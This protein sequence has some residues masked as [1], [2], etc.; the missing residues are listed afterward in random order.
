[1]RD[2]AGHGGQTTNMPPTPS[3]D[4][5]LVEICV[6]DHGVAIPAEH[7]AQ[8]FEP[9]YRVDT[10]LAREVNGLGVGLAICKSIVELHGGRIWAE[11]ALGAG[12]TFHVWLPMGGVWRRSLKGATRMP[13]KKTTILVVD[14]DLQLLKIVIHNLRAEGYQVLTAQEG[15]HALETI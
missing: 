7:L 2:G 9:F 6:R 12:S 15:K 14:D 8:V 3:G 5:G 1:Q 10:R 4:Q 11:S 13:A